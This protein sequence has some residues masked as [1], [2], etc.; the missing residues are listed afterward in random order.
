MQNRASKTA[1]DVL[2]ARAINSIAP[3]HKRLINDTFAVH[4]LPATWFPV[5]MYLNMGMLRPFNYYISNFFSEQVG[6]MGGA[7]II[8]LRHRY[9]DDRLRDAYAQGIRQVVILG[10]GYDSRAWRLCL[11]DVFFVEVDHPA[12]Q[13]NKIRKIKKMGGGNKKNLEMVPVDFCD[14]WV[15]T[16]MNSGK[17]KNEPTFFIWEGVSMYLPKEA[18]LNTIEGIK[19]MAPCGSRLIFDHY[20]LDITNSMTDDRTI[21]KIQRYGIRRGEPFLWG[22]GRDEMYMVLTG[23]GYSRVKNT[24]MGEF[25]RKLDGKEGIRIN[26]KYAYDLMIMSEGWLDAK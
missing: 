6:G 19:K 23:C 3:K 18:V 13:K 9:I 7:N 20:P 4:F 2:A 22:C 21:K 11:D 14:D 15:S 17:I 5:K 8:A 26:R 25:A 24:T 10:A 16:L 1:V 12:T